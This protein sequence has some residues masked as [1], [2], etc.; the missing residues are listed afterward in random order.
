MRFHAGQ[1]GLSAAGAASEEAAPEFI[2]GEERFSAPEKATP[3]KDALKR[4]AVCFVG[5]W[6][7]ERGESPEFIRGE[8]RFRA[9]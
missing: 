4:W 8:E 1:L 2:R 3:L 5:G 7:R 9:R 6:S